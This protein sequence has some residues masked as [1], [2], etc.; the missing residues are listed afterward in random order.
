MKAV[1]GCLAVV[2]AAATHTQPPVIDDSPGTVAWASARVKWKKRPVDEGTI[3]DV[4]A[5]GACP[6]GMAN[7][8]DRYCVDRWEASLDGERAVSMPGVMPAGYVSGVQAARACKLSGK[9]L[10]S[11]AEWRFA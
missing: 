11:A 7:V 5:D 9:R 10:C 8:A 2:I 6:D 4:V 1:L 3:P